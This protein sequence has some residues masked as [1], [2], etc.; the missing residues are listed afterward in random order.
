LYLLGGQPI[1]CHWWDADGHTLDEWKECT[2]VIGF[3]DPYRMAIHKAL[4]GSLS[5]PGYTGTTILRSFAPDHFEDGEWDN[6]GQCVRIS[7]GGVPMRDLTKYMYDI[8]I[9]EFQNVTGTLSSIP[10]CL[11][12]FD[13]PLSLISNLMFWMLHR[14]FEC[15]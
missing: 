11:A 2:K 7:P 1:G 3:A 10:D 8:Q 13:A 6:G 4:E 5:I 9:Q 15:F 12:T 14:C